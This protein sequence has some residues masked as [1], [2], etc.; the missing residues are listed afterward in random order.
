MI[1]KRAVFKWEEKNTY[2]DLYP[3]EQKILIIL[4]FPFARGTAEKLISVPTQ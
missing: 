1:G 2:A 3:W 4:G